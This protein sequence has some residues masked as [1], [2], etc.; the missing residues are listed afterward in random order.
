MTTVCQGI[1]DEYEKNYGCKCTVITNAG[2]YEDLSA[3]PL[4]DGRVRMIHHGGVNPSRKIENMLE[5]M[6]QLDERFRL[7]LMLVDNGSSYYRKLRALARDNDRVRFRDPVPM[8]DISRTINEYDIGLYLLPAG[9][10]N[11]RMALPNKLFEFIQA[12]LAIAIWP[13]P[14]MARIVREHGCGVVCEDY[15]VGSM[16]KCLNRLS[17]EDIM[18]FKERANEASAVLCAE[19]NMETFNQLVDALLIS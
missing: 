5:L 3:K 4:L 1:A 2:F 14:E 17:S 8:K 9:G 19:S 15:T 18:L 10:F 7:D 13:S 12:R 11:N 16:A 6:N